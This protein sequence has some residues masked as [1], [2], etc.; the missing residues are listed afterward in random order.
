MALDCL[1]GD[2]LL[3]KKT[4]YNNR[5]KVGQLHIRFRS[6]RDIGRKAFGREIAMAARAFLVITIILFGMQGLSFGGT[7]KPF[8]Q[9]GMVAAQPTVTVEIYIT[10]WCPYCAQAIKF[11]QDNRIPYVAY[12]IEKDSEAA[13]RKERLS[14]RQGVPFAIINGKKIYG[15]SAQVYSQTLGLK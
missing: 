7:N 5:A 2:F 4:I 14:P 13:R 11:L 12:D 15:F 1:I 9:T 6:E 10:S 3:S 8:G